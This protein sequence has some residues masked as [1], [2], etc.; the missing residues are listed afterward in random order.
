MR[1]LTKKTKQ[2]TQ[3]TTLLK[4]VM[5]LMLVF[6]GFASQ[7]Q[8]PTYD[9]Y[10]TN[11]SQVDSKTYQF[12]VYVLRTGSS[13]LEMAG[14][15]LGIGMDTSITNGG[16][17]TFSFVSGSSELVSTQVP[18][19]FIVGNAF[20]NVNGIIYRCLNQTA[21]TGPGAGN[22]TV[23]SATKNG[24]TAP[25][26]RIGTYRLTN[27]RDFKSASSAKHVFNT[28]TAAQRTNTAVTCYVNGVNVTAV[29]TVY[30][31]NTT[32]TCDQNLSLNGCAV[33]AGVSTTS[34][35][36]FGQ[37]TGSATVTLSGAGTSSTGTYTLDGGSSVAYS[38]NPFT[39]S[40]LSA[41]SHTVAVTTAGSCQASTGSFTVS[42]PA[43]PA[44][45][46]TTRS[47]CTSYLWNGT[48]Y[49]TS[50]VKTFNTTSAAGCD[51]TATLNLTIK[52]ATSSSSSA[53]V[54][55]SALPYQ[56]N[57]SNYTASGVYTFTATNAVGCDSTVTLNLTVKSNSSSSTSPTVCAASLPYSWNGVSYTASGVYTFST[58]NAAGCDSVATLNLTV[59]QNAA[60]TTPVSVCVAALP[61]NWN[62]TN[63]TA[64]GTYTFNT[65]TTSGCDSVATLVLSVKV[66][67][68]SLTNV[69]V[70]SS[71]VP[72]VLPYV[73]NGTSYSV[74]GLY[75]FTTTNA[76]GCDSLARLNLSV[77]STTPTVSPAITQVLISNLCGARKYRYTAATTANAT[78]YNWIL[79]T[80]VGGESGVTLDSGDATSS[81]VIVLTYASNKAAIST[82]SIKVRAYSGCGFTAYKAAKLSNAALNVPAAPTA[83]TITPL[84]TNVCGNRVYR[85]S[86][87]S[88]PV[89]S[90]TAAAA[91]GYVWSFVG[92]L[93][94]F[95]TIDSGDVNDQRIVVSYTS[96]AASATGDS[97]KLYYTSGCGNSL[98]KAAK[99]SNT[100]LKAPAAPT[101]VTITPLQTNVCGARRYRYSAPELPGASTTAG[102]ASGYVWD[103]IG[104]LAST[105]TI[106]SGDL[107][108]RRF[109]VTFT[110]NAA[111]AAGD[112]VRVFYTTAGEG[113]GNSP[114]KSAKLSNTLLKAPSAAT[115]VTIT[116]LQ[117]NVCS[118][119]RY[120][121]SAPNLPVAS[122]TAGAANGYVWDV[123]GSLASTMTVD[124]GNLFGQRFTVTFTSNAAS[125]AGDS[126]RV[127]YTSAGCG[128]S[129]LKSAKL[130]NTLLAAPAAPTTV[131]IQQV[132]PDVC[133][134]RKYRYIAPAVLPGASA[135]AGAANG[136]LW[137]APTG[138]VGSTGTIDSGN[139][140]SSI[141]VVTYTSNAAAGAGDSIRL[142]Y[143]SAGCGDGVIKAAKLSNL[144]KAGCTPIAKNTS[145][146]RVP[147]SLPTSM[148]VKVYPNPTTTQFNVQVKSSG[149]EEAVVRV[150]DLTGRFIKSV[151]VSSN[152]NVNLGADLKAGAYMLEVRQG[153]EVKTVRVMKF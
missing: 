59:A 142:R 138:T 146:S 3:K 46:S 28:T 89:A 109:T 100:A 45:S 69:S 106:D 79:P 20:Y 94:E 119:R 129:P 144:L 33:S 5:S 12:D 60:S 153:K 6:L 72:S 88:L 42:G 87:P 127:L 151:K 120:R 55:P 116:P 122:T 107:I 82:D 9:M 145:T 148:E 115:A 114:R 125:A 130:S 85:Y 65:A 32:N 68:T 84:I 118:E 112:S 99:L 58:S 66:A 30:N 150:L 25:G 31:Y 91:T 52:N 105:M 131:T 23:I 132:L 95:S 98:T 73:W 41:G 17:L 47:E 64:S 16:T 15:Q 38:S 18:Q 83:V 137:S 143:T 86:A 27:T 111:S 43:G 37:S 34:V 110:S 96:N 123:I 13:T 124:S 90:A 77:T 53:S 14:I 7:A 49:T 57:G 10:I 104:S 80:S 48:T 19:T 22:G 102:A 40:N 44:T 117:T 75:S 147:N 62:G 78:G 97:I 113:C 101:A 74:S 140:N 71:T 61:Y 152:S 24:C 29:G 128:N 51:S 21:R 81:R 8:N 139:V 26:T 2:M 136:Y 121:Y 1:I 67:T 4:H 35:V 36:C 141:I 70:C 108:S 39:V 11:Q 133:N 103:V 56:W 76:A 92:S 63:Y 54:C 50:G 93:S 135:T 134:A 126:V 149:T